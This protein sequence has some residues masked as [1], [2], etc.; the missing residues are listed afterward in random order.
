MLRD[1]IRT[2]NVLLDDK[3]DVEVKTI[4]ADGLKRRGGVILQPQPYDSPNDP[5]MWCV[6]KP[7]EHGQVTLS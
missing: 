2:R 1:Q 4:G 3:K 6:H 5:L 7:G